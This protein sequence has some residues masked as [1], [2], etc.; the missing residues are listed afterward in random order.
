MN[1]GGVG[2]VTTF[3]YAKDHFATWEFAKANWLKPT[4]TL[5]FLHFAHSKEGIGIKQK[6]NSIR[7]LLPQIKLNFYFIPVQTQFFIA[8]LNGR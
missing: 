8:A 7:G 4:Q 6:F 2:F 1:C 3:A 5:K